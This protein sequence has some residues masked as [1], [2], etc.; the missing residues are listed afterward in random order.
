LKDND[1]A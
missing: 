1:H